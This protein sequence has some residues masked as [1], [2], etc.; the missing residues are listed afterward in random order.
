MALGD[1]I[2]SRRQELR[3][4]TRAVARR[5][6]VNQSAIVQWE[7]GGGIRPTHLVALA[8]VLELDLSRLFREG[9]DRAE[10]VQDPD[11]LAALA[12]YRSLPP[13]MRGTMIRMMSGLAT[14]DPAGQS[15]LAPVDEPQKAV[16]RGR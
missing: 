9:P 1:L 8:A 13:D 5:L 4:S 7:A 16:V 3:L 12:A 15:R 10:L 6:G 14:N 11:E 2:R